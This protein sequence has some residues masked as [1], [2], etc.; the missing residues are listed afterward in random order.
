MPTLDVRRS[1]LGAARKSVQDRWGNGRRV[2]H[3]EQRG[4]GSYAMKHAAAPGATRE[5]ELLLQCSSLS[6]TPRPVGLAGEV[7]AA[8]ADEQ[9]VDERRRQCSE[10]GRHLRIAVVIDPPR[11]DAEGAD[12][13]KSGDGATARRLRGN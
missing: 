2:E 5:L 6:F 7:E 1:Q 8:F 3:V 10:G 12:P 11:V 13:A 9:T 4:V